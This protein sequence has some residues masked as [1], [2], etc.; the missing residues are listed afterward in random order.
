MIDPSPGTQALTI[1]QT[2]D[3]A[4]E[5]HTA[6]R[7]PEA[8]SLYQQILQT[9][10]N[11]PVALHLLGLIAYQV[12]NNE[13]AVDLIARAITVQPDYTEAH[14]NLGLALQSMRKLEEAVAQYKKAIA[15]SPG[16]A[17]AHNNLG[18]GLR[19]LGQLEEAIASSRT[20]IA[21]RPNLA[22]AHYNLGHALQ[23]LKNLEGAMECYHKAIALQPEFAVA[24]NNLG[25]VFQD[26]G[27]LDEAMA[28]YHKAIAIQ[29]D[30]ATA[31]YNIGNTLR[32][33][34]N[35]KEAI[36]R[37]HQALAI[38]PDYV[39]ALNN[40]GNALHDLGKLDEAIDC[41]RNAIAINSDLAEVHNN[42]GATLT[43]LGRLDE[44]MTSYRNALAVDQEFAD[45]H[46]N[47]AYALLMQGKWRE[48]WEKY[49]WRL[50]TK[51]CQTPLLPI[52]MW[53]GISLQ[54]K[55]I[56][57]YAE[58]G[59]GDEIMFASCLGDLLE[60]SPDTLY[61]E[62][63]S[64]L[65]ALFARS[66]PDVRVHGKT[67]DIDLSWL[68]D[69]AQPDYSL[70][71]GSLPK[72]FRNH[73]SEFPDRAAYLTPH[74]DL[75][76]KWTGRLADLK[77]GLKIGISWKGGSAAKI[78]K[79]VSIPLPEWRPLLAMNASFINLQYGELS[80]DFAILSDLEIHDWD[81]N[82]PLKDL[83]N[84]AALISCLDLVISV[85]N[86][87]VHMCGALGTNTWTLLPQVPEW[88][89]PE[90]FGDFPPLY[91][92]VRLFRQKNLFKWDDVMD[93][94]AQALSDLIANGPDQKQS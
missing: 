5:H 50:K 51:D 33:M 47:M 71:I 94:V 40:L 1:Q 55:S 37:Y 9:D 10:P 8:E 75:V 45:S 34:D 82:D 43:D 93:R 24:H 36:E 11:Q 88:R 87:T 42:L 67:R 46:K 92:S 72:F 28:C 17:E 4:V 70:P 31:H 73:V 62:C 79:R 74:P 85:D 78:V 41:F 59:V 48:G 53:P 29:S 32:D 68:G 80:E 23:D 6:G 84:Q 19:E 7:L 21:L 52:E 30:Y 2:L 69:D 20:A 26:L 49:T 13:I 22:T 65:E 77:D 86:A 56:I 83:D 57:L 35:P 54:G 16:F 64:R 18:A 3:L 58:Q 89:W 14:S 25:L 44:A 12:G 39:E 90:A 27:K 61:L 60:Q 91:P 38:K 66:F 81:D 15:I 63:D 76:A